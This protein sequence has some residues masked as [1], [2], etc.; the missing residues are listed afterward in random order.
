MTFCQ[1]HRNLLQH[2]HLTSH[3][4]SWQ[5]KQHLLHIIL[6]ACVF[7]LDARRKLGCPQRLLWCLL[8]ATQMIKIISYIVIAFC[9]RKANILCRWCNV[10]YIFYKNKGLCHCCRSY[11]FGWK[12]ALLHWILNL[13]YVSVQVHC[14]NLMAVQYMNCNNEHTGHRILF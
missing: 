14:R 3:N 5:S 7:C 2:T 11:W 8:A 9:Y 1:Q 12:L 4:Q 10:L 13:C 6:L